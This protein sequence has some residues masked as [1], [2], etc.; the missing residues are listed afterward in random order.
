MNAP[1]SVRDA[2][3]V[4]DL[5]APPETMSVRA[6]ATAAATAAGVEI[7]V[8]DD[9]DALA[10]IER[11]WSSTWYPGTD[12]SPATRDLMRA[13]THAGAYLGAAYDDER[14]LA[15]SF[16]FFGLPAHQH[17]HSHLAAVV[18]DA[19]G[20][21]IGMALKLHQRSWALDQGVAAV[22]WTV[23][24]LVRRNAHFNIAKLGAT[25]VE[26]LADFYGE[27]S[28]INAGQGSDRLLMSWPVAELVDAA[29]G[30]LDA[31]A[32]DGEPLLTEDV[33]GRPRAAARQDVARPALVQVPPD[34]ER[35]RVTH[36][37]L[38]RSWRTAV[39]ET[40]GDLMADGGRIAGFTRDGSYVVETTSNE[41]G[42]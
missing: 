39:R 37:A 2:G 29:P 34:I 20:R 5:V 9:L 3:R 27:M 38:S 10:D 11:L 18:A 24:P 25:P 41:A 16:G 35:L 19:R 1:P 28:G 31:G 7:R 8:V 23:D 36:P 13:M 4:T 17:L 40:L 22:T 21:N 14:L 32:V 42:L 6:A 33:T 30:A 12:K 15:A 26:Y